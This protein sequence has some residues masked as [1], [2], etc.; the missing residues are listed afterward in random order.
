MQVGR[1]R[2]PGAEGIRCGRKG[3]DGA[4]PSGEETSGRGFGWRQPKGGGGWATRGHWGDHPGRPWGGELRP[5]WDGASRGGGGDGPVD[6]TD[7]PGRRRGEGCGG[8]GVRGQPEPG[9]GGNTRTLGL[10][11]RELE[12]ML[13]GRVTGWRLG[14]S[15][16]VMA[17]PAA[18]R[19]VVE[20]DSDPLQDTTVGMLLAPTAGL[21]IGELFPRRHPGR[22]EVDG[23]TIGGPGGAAVGA[24]RGGGGA[25]KGTLVG[26][27]GRG[28][29]WAG[30]GR[31]G[32]A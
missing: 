2:P 14:G 27:W 31:G 20:E 24:R 3:G 15:G 13:E 28:R 21:W 12:T 6:R 26:G 17:C 11:W 10:R 5:I 16:E 29:V 19:L 22:P 9:R 7:T 23:G 25:T 8:G 30:N 18:N 32:D 1:E 4:G